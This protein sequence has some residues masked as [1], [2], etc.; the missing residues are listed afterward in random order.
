MAATPSRPKLLVIVGPTA[1][2][3]SEL[4]LNIAKKYNG[5][6]IAADS[7]TVYRDMN[8]G[9]AKPSLDDQKALLHWG[10]DLVNP[11][12]RFTAADFKQ[13]AEAK[14]VDIQKRGKLPLLVGGTGL[15]IDSVLFDFGFLADFDPKLRKELEQLS[16]QDLQKIIKQRGYTMPTNYQNKRYLIRV[17]ET[18]S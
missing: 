14:I 17:I 1:S 5:E 11:G 4:A 8:I 2:G 9:T 18:K 7:R 3:K 12:Q 13:Y 15:Y 6:I 16:V 10:L